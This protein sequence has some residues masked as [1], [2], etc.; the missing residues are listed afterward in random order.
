MANQASAGLS[1]KLQGLSQ[2]QLLEVARGMGVN[3]LTT[4]FFTGLATAQ[5]SQ[6][7]LLPPGMT[8]DDLVSEI[9]S[10]ARLPW[11]KMHSR[12]LLDLVHPPELREK[13]EALPETKFRSLIKRANRYFVADKAVAVM[14]DTVG[15]AIA[16]IDLED[17]LSSLDSRMAMVPNMERLKK[18]EPTLLPLLSREEMMQYFTPNLY[19]KVGV[20]GHMQLVQYLKRLAKGTLGCR[21]FGALIAKNKQ[22]QLSF[23][24]PSSI[25]V[26]LLNNLENQERF[27]TASAAFSQV[28]VHRLSHTNLL[29]K[30]ALSPAFTKPMLESFK[31][32]PTPDLRKL[33]ST[34]KAQL[35]NAYS[36][37]LFDRVA[38]ELTAFDVRSVFKQRQIELLINHVPELQNSC[39]KD[40]TKKDFMEFF[41][42][43]VLQDGMQKL[44]ET[45]LRQLMTRALYLVNTSFTA[46]LFRKAINSVTE[47]LS[48]QK[49]VID[50]W[51]PQL[52][53]RVVTTVNT[54]KMQEINHWKAPA[55][56]AE[57]ILERVVDVDVK[58]TLADF[59]KDE[60]LVFFHQ[61]KAFSGERVIA[62]IFEG[63]SRDLQ[64]PDLYR[65][66]DAV[67]AHPTPR[68][69]VVF[70]LMGLIDQQ[71]VH[72]LSTRE[73]IDSVARGIEEEVGPE[74][75]TVEYLVQEVFNKPGEFKKV[76][77]KLFDE[78]TCS[79]GYHMF[80]KLCSELPDF[81]LRD[82]ITDYTNRQ[83]LPSLVHA[84]LPSLTLNNGAIQA[85]GVELL[86][87]AEDQDDMYDKLVNDLRV[88]PKQ[89]LVEIFNKMA[90]YLETTRT[91]G[92][93]FHL[94]ETSLGA[95]EH[96]RRQRAAE[97]EAVSLMKLHIQE[98]PADI[99]QTLDQLDAER[100]T[101]RLEE[102]KRKVLGKYIQNDT[103]LTLI[104]HY[105]LQQ[106]QHFFAELKDMC[107]DTVEGPK[108]GSTTALDDY[109]AEAALKKDA[110]DND[111]TN[112]DT[113]VTD[114]E[115]D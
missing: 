10:V 56:L 75:D 63:A 107:D 102:E 71:P 103:I 28:D 110:E 20:Q 78:F 79:I 46:R 27:V 64:P 8:L 38:D 59:S 112:A 81:D 108:Q 91:I 113:V 95:T 67:F 50:S 99:F 47:E 85:T 74:D 48:A 54:L 2:R 55:F 42:F 98:D 12:A 34:V 65:R 31:T 100:F 51:T 1:L 114:N 88:I 92:K 101:E 21:I 22:K 89:N 32:V 5:I 18:L 29:K 16:E 94:Y 61:I 57:D 7:D 86:Q 104:A 109:E 41:P 23:E 49:T 115:E 40:M 82:V 83:L 35:G 87:I 26:L 30:L 111:A 17:M 68:R 37:R 105:D 33:L 90:T 45:Q 3:Q 14:V 80:L 19:S 4:D 36:S 96:E 39:I 62:N 13:L 60:L 73:V 77:I 72:R 69:R 43:K 97:R 9:A 15:G 76:M 106:V 58:H 44:T 70:G 24:L 6:G 66:F 84:C 93:F 25:K 53:D 11:K 52:I